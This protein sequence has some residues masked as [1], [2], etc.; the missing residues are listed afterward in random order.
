MPQAPSPLDVLL[1]PFLRLREV[2]CLAAESWPD[3]AGLVRIKRAKFRKPIRPT[4][5]LMLE[6]KRKGH[7]P[8]VTFEYSRD[9]ETCSGGS[10]EFG[11]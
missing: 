10:L 8:H 4:D 1:A 9:G 11:E 2:A 3:L 7:T 5:E 6:L